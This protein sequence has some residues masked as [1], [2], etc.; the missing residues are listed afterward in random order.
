[1]IFN[2]IPVIMY[3]HVMPE[4]KELNVTPEVFEE[5]ISLLKR[6]GW[7]S[8]DGKEFL[9]LMQNP[10][11]SKRKCILLT[12][13]DGFLD[14]YI[15]AY[16]ILKK[17]RM[18]AIL[19]VATDFITDSYIKRDDFKPME[20][21]EIWRLAYTDRKYEVMCTWNELREMQYSDVFDIESHGHSHRI[22]EF[23][24][25]SDY[26]KV[27]NDLK[28]GIDLVIR[29]LNKKPLHLAWPKG[30][31]NEKAVEIAKELGFRALYTTKRG[32]NTEDLLHIKRMAIKCKG[33]HW[34]KTRLRIYSSSL[35]SKIYSKIKF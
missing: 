31:Y 2:S 11:E 26:G 5:Q 10:K 13:D 22:P 1:M 24:K 9:Y 18:K 23:V 19:F 3:H 8:L 30:V 20:H 12:F 4:I 6:K 27:E 34:F 28:L 35:L 14:N 25:N 33:S 7:K 29:Y 16:P 17:Y 21:K 15:Y 32:A